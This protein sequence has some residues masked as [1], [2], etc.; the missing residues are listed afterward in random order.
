MQIEPRIALLEDILAPYRA[1]LGADFEGYHNHVCRV[2]HFCLA[3]RDCT[4]AERERVVIAGCFHDIGIWTEGTLDYLPPSHAEAVAWLRT[5][6]RE[7]EA[8]EVTL[9]IDLHHRLRAV[10]D[11]RYPLVEVFRRADLVDVSLGLVTF[12]L[13]RAYVRA[14]QAQFP[15]A[16]FH[17]RLAQL[18]GQWFRAHPFRVPPFMKW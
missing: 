10:K 7:Q 13:P 15:D 2:V 1:Q 12:G 18:G 17:R 4:P 16:G 3:L 8:E 5:E 9:M 6:G 11:A 14:V